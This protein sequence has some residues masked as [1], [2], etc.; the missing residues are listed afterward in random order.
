[1]G[2]NSTVVLTL[3]LLTLMFGAGAVSGSWGYSLGRDALKGITQ[4][5]VRPTNNMPGAKRNKPGQG[6][7]ALLKEKDIV[8]TVKARMNGQDKEPDKPVPK[9]NTPGSKNNKSSQAKKSTEPAK[10]KFPLTTNS[11]GVSFEV[12]SVRQRGGYLVLDVTMKNQGSQTVKFL[13]S[14]L[15]VTDNQGRPLSA[16]ADDLPGELAPNG[17]TFEGTVSIPTA[18]LNNAKEISLNLT[19]YPNQQV[20]LKVSGIPINN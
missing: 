20:Q 9:E 5:D 11:N 15:N 10:S 7:V 19:D 14:F 1:M 18:L 16:T 6:E 13:Y 3:G 4:P 8:K 12:S 2:I 17:E